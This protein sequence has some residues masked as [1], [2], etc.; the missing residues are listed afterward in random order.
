[1]TASLIEVVWI[2]SDE[3]DTIVI[4]DSDDD[5]HPQN[6]DVNKT[7]TT[8]HSGKRNSSD[9]FQ[10]GTVTNERHTFDSSPTEIVSRFRNDLHI[11]RNV[12]AK[13]SDRPTCNLKVE[14]KRLKRD[15]H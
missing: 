10:K 11:A 13:V 6:R 1:M 3:S 15:L 5:F 2:S 14:M 12:C 8:T 9:T 7:T 4:S